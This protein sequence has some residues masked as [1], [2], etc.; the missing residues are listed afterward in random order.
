MNERGWRG[1]D[2][3]FKDLKGN[4]VF[5]GRGIKSKKSAFNLRHLCSKPHTGRQFG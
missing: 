4:R 1:L 5:D 3:G 2:A